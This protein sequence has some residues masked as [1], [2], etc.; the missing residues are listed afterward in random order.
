M[1]DEPPL[2]WVAWFGTR[3]YVQADVAAAEVS[4]VVTLHW[5]YLWGYGLET[6]GGRRVNRGCREKWKGNFMQTYLL[7]D[8]QNPA[9]DPRSGVRECLSRLARGLRSQWKRRAEG[10]GDVRGSET[11]VK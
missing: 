7:E 5:V 6:I 8:K 4:G 10:K 11:L 1:P 2:V 9:H 3:D